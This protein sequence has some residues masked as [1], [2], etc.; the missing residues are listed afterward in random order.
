MTDTEP[1]DPLLRRD[2]PEGE[3][4]RQADTAPDIRRR[5]LAGAR[6]LALRGVVVRGLGFLAN[7]VLIRLLSPADLGLAAIGAAVVSFAAFLGDGGFSAVLIR[8]VNPPTPRELSLVRNAQL[9]IATAAALL[10]LAFLPV[11]EHRTLVV[12]GFLATLPLIAMRVPVLVMAEREMDYRPLARSEMVQAIAYPLVALPLAALGLGVWALVI[13]ALTRATAGTVWLLSRHHLALPRAWRIREAAGVLRAGLGYQAISLALLA[14]DELANIVIVAVSTLRILGLYNL[15]AT[16][17]QIPG[18]ILDSLFRVSFGA[19]ASVLREGR[20]LTSAVKKMVM[21]TA[22][23][24]AVLVGCI[25][26]AAPKGTLFLLGERWAAA[27]PAILYYALAVLIVAPLG[28]GASGALQAVGKPVRVAAA[29]GANAVVLILVLTVLV[30]N[31]GAAGAGLAYLVSGCVE[32]AVLLIALRGV[33]RLGSLS[34]ELAVVAVG[35][36]ASGLAYVIADLMPSGLAGTAI[37][38]AIGG[39]LT[40]LLVAITAPAGF[41]DTRSVIRSAVLPATR[42]K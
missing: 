6:A 21:T 30:P 27:A 25:C 29:I 1:S 35:C 15:A 33:I 11:F 10:S 16:V 2:P 12:T 22:M 23:T 9:T 24:T 31:F 14:R 3:L 18:L 40:L 7:L 8:R 28:V 20:D 13:A 17:M 5:T 42:L 37:G 32:S 36:A 39:A 4:V 26:G 19:L 38:V 34:R 41:R